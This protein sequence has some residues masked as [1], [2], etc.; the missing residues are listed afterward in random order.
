M[1]IEHKQNNG[2]VI[3]LKKGLTEIDSIKCSLSKFAIEINTYIFPDRNPYIFNQTQ[4]KL[5]SGYGK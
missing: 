3:F 4:T 2:N 5:I 1:Y